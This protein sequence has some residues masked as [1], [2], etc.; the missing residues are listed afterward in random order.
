MDI[1]LS[2][3]IAFLIYL[4][5]TFFFVILGKIMAGK[6]TIKFSKIQHIRQWRVSAHPYGR[7]RVPAFFPDR[8]FLR[9]SASRDSC[10]GHQ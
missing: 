2:P 5:L 9:H 8:I 3:P 7:S 10:I 6:T 1:L 4:P